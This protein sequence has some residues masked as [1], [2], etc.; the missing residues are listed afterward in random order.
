MS[1]SCSFN[2]FTRLVHLHKDGVKPKQTRCKV[3]HCASQGD[4]YLSRKTVDAMTTSGSSHMQFEWFK[5]E[6]HRSCLFEHA[7]RCTYILVGGLVERDQVGV[8]ASQS[9]H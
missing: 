5:L 2:V 7:E 1:S 3:Q 9:H 8:E 6:W 4:S